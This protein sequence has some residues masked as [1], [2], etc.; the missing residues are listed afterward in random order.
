[1]TRTTQ[2]KVAEARAR[3]VAPYATEARRA[4]AQAH[5]AIDH[6]D[7]ATAVAHARTLKGVLWHAERVG[8]GRADIA[9]ALSAGAD[10]TRTSPFTSTS[11]QDV[12]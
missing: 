1:M 11:S 3:T 2:H 7:A 8:V 9:A 12:S 6:L 10:R 5:E 4:M